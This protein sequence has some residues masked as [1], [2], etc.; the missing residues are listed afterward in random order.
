MQCGPD[1]PVLFDLAS[2]EPPDLVPDRRELHFIG[3]KLHD[4]PRVDLVCEHCVCH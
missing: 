4:M 3:S 1:G 2:R